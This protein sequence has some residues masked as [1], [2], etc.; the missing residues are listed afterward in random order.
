MDWM[1][2]ALSTVLSTFL[3][4]QRQKQRW[5]KVGLII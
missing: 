2:V 1:K 5:V 4:D 3:K